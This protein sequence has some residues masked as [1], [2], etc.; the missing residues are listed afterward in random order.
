MWSWRS[1][2]DRERQ[3][4]GCLSCVELE[5]FVRIERDRAGGCFI[6]VEL[7]ESVRIERDRAGGCLISVEL[8]EL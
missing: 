5:E 8:E 3:S 4:R 2:E 1:C 7:E 6:C